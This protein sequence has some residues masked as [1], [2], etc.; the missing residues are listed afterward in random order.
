[1]VEATLPRKTATKS[2]DGAKDQE[3]VN[4]N[5]ALPVGQAEFLRIASFEHRVP[6]AALVREALDDL[7]KKYARKK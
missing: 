2:P 7:E 6:Q 3:F 5:F 1:M 4:R